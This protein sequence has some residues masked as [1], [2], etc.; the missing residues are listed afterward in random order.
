MDAPSHQRIPSG[1]DTV[2]IPDGMNCLSVLKIL[3]FRR[4]RRSLRV[5]TF[6]FL[7]RLILCSRVALC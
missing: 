7:T 1:Q 5:G 4:H 3:V 2:G 6:V